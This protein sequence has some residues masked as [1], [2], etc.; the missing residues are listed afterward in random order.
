VRKKDGALRICI[1][2]TMLNGV[3]KVD[4]HPIA[5]VDMMID[6]LGQARYI[7]TLD[8][9]KGYASTSSEEK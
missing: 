7:T 4:A 8:L 9:T 2:Y 1:D 5:R 6:R 3:T